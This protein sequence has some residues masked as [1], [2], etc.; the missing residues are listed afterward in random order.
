MGV[1]SV[2]VGIIGAFLPLLPTTPFV[3]F[4]AWCFVESSPK[5]HAWLLNHPTLGPFIKNWQ[6]NRSL[7]RKS[8]MIATLMIII[9]V[10]FM[11]IKLKIMPIKV[12]NMCIMT[13][14]IQ[15]IWERPENTLEK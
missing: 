14:V 6:N 12:M 10:I 5:A 15:Y 4:A 1:T 7:S 13:L 2:I 11:L 8:K 9:S 3:L